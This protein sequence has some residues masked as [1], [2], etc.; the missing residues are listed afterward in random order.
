LRL[1]KQKRRIEV[2]LLGGTSNNLRDVVRHALVRPSN[3]DHLGNFI[4]RHSVALGAIE[5]RCRL[6]RLAGCAADYRLRQQ[7]H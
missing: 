1:A 6:R 3:P 5:I 2:V 4:Q 7:L